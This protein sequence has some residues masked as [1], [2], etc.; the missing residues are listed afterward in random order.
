L[1]LILAVFGVNKFAHFLPMPEDIPAAAGVLMQ[2]FAE[3]G[4]IFQA[5]GVVEVV[6]G[7]LLLLNLFAPLAAALF[8]PITVN[9]L[10]FHLNL[11]FA[12]IGLAAVVGALNIVLLF[13]YLPAYMPM[14]SIRPKRGG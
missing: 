9:I 10:L 11:D 14:L 2:A 12:G 4:Y 5:V 6:V 3:S 7:V 8:V 1:G 13:F